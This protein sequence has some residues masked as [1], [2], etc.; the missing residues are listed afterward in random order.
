[1][2]DIDRADDVELQYGYSVLREV[3]SQVG[4]IVDKHAKRTAAELSDGTGVLSPVSQTL[5]DRFAVFGSDVSVE[6]LCELAYG[7]LKFVRA[8]T[9]TARKG[10]PLR[11]RIHVR[12]G[13]TW[14][15]AREVREA[16]MMPEEL[17]ELLIGKARRALAEG[18]RAG[19]NNVCY[20]KGLDGECQ[21]WQPPQSDSPSAPDR[22][23]DQDSPPTPAQ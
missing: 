3:T 12:A 21:L 22:S 23:D 7:I 8:T 14:L 4:E 6:Q 2:L 16:R 5:T 11:V 18:A 10:A 13:I 1:M 19:G 17:T 20:A 15:G 9:S